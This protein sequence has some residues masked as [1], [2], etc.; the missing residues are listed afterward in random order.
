MKERRVSKGQRLARERARKV[1][2][3]QR[4]AERRRRLTIAGAGVAVVVLALGALVAVRLAGHGGSSAAPAPAATQASQELTAKL[5]A[6]PG[7]V[8]DAVGTGTVS[9]VPTVISGQPP[10]TDGGK[11]LVLYV[12]AEYCPYCAA[13]RWAVVVAL[14]RFGSFSGLGQTHSS[15]TDVFPNT[16]TLSFHGA[17][18]TSEYLSFQGVETQ[19][20]QPQGN[21]YAPLDPLTPAQES[22]VRKYNA[23]PYVPAQSAGS[24]PFIDFGNQGLV[25]GA[26]FSP[27]LL[28]GKTAEEIAGALTD[29]GNEITKAVGGTANAITTLVCQ[30]TG[31]QPGPVCTSTAA[32]AY[33]GKLHADS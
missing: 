25:S 26:S 31:N 17:T 32:M 14:S 21:G 5:A 6:V 12:G 11:P 16:A 28:S 4:R 24:I 3:A 27:Q 1:V 19:S 9:T 20:N 2:A 13:E 18:Y 8:L 22:V 7:T 15:S 10:L 23:P 29:P 30:L 33:Q